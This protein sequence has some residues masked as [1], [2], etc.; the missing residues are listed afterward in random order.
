MK[1]KKPTHG[2]AVVAGVV[3]VLSLTL[4]PAALAAKGGGSGGGSTGGTGAAIT[5]SPA[6]VSVGQQYTVS[7]SGM[8]AN[9]WVVVGADFPYPTMTVWCS[10]YADAAGNWSCTFTASQAGDIVH[11]VYTMGNNGR[12]RLQGSASLMISG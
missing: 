4:V 2:T 11:Q 9:S 12:L 1:F 7:V 8:G 6:P 3:L 5:F 10:H